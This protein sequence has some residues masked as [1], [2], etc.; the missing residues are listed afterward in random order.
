MSLS[1]KAVVTNEQALEISNSYNFHNL[2]TR[3]SIKPYFTHENF[4]RCSHEG[5]IPHQFRHMDR[6]GRRAVR[7]ALSIEPSGRRRHAS[8]H[9]RGSSDFLNG[10]GKKEQIGNHITSAIIG[11]V[12]GVIYTK[13]SA[14]LSGHG[15]SPTTSIS[16][17]VL[18]LT[19]VLCAIHGIFKP[20]GLFCSIPMMFGAIA[21]TFFA[22]TDK[23]LYLMVTL[24]LGVL[25]GY[26]CIYGTQVLDQDGK[27][28]FFRSRAKEPLS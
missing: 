12:W 10:G 7:L 18:V 2:T 25:L 28:T 24:S 20:Y 17:V 1:A 9:V 13:C 14:F 8:L 19:T 11:V 16:L 26:A 22:G 15:M 27:W 5:T 4:E 23:W 6:R 3:K 21:S